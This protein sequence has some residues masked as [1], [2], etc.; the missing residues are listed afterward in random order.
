L[1]GA[2]IQVK[3]VDDR[4]FLQALVTNGSEGSF[5]PNTQMDDYPGFLMGLWYDLGGSWN[6]QKKAWDLFGDCISDVDYTCQPVVR[7]GGCVNLVP[8]DRRSLY[9][10]AEQSRY[11]VTPAGPGGTRLI[12][13]LNGDAATPNGAHAV[14][15][16]DADTYNAF[17]A[18]KYH[19]FSVAN[20]W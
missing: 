12:N 13:V 3:A 11:F 9:G 20:E 6:E 5:Q 1:M 17:V 16:F 7:F 2:G 15:K 8:L 4:F 19:G 10:D 18:A 14:D